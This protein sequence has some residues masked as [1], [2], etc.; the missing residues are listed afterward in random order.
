MI[1]KIKRFGINFSLKNISF[2]NIRV[3]EKEEEYFKK[4]EN[5]ILISFIS[6]ILI[7][8]GVISFRD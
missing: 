6:V 4:N 3:F 7:D 1:K 2:I 8:L 5:Y